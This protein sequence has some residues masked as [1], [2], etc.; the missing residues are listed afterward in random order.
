MFA[1]ILLPVDLADRH[2]AALTQA[3][4]LARHS[5]GAVELF[6]VIETLVGL[7]VEE[8]RDFYARLEQAA[9][10]HLDKLGRMLDAAGVA[11]RA[12]VQLGQRGATIVMHARE[13]GAD[14]IVL[15]SPRLDPAS[16]AGWGSLSF[17]ISFLSACPVLLVK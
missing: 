7:P 6:H 9:R 8:E 15:T 16:A 1:N 3:A 2:E 5:G 11:W 17:K 14:L 4:E 12:R 10:K 13:S